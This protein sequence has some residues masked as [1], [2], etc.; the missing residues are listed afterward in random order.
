[1]VRSVPPIIGLLLAAVCCAPPA[2]AQAPAERQSSRSGA[3][4]DLDLIREAAS[5]ESAGDLR[6][7]ER[8]VAEV[9]AANP[10]SLTALLAYERLLT[11]Q[12]RPADVLPVVDRLL[13][14]DPTSGIGH[15]MRLR[16][17]ARGGDGS[18]IEAA[19]AAWIQAMPHLETPYR[20]AA[21]VWRQRAEPHRAVAVL[22]QGRH[23]IDRADALA[24]EL[25]DALLDAGDPPRAAVEWARAVGGDGRGFML[26]QRRVFE[27]PDGGAGIIPALIEQLSAPPRTPGRQ[28]S[29]VLLAIDA[30]LEPYA[31]DLATDLVTV[32]P[33]AERQP[34]FVEL[35]RR[36]DGAAMYGLA[37]WAYRV[38]LTAEPEPAAALA[39]RTRVAELALLAGDTALAA[40][41]YRQL[42]DA[43]AVGSPQ[44]R[45]ATAL[46][47]QL[48]AREGDLDAAA[49]ELDT[50]RTE[51]PQAPELDET[52]AVVAAGYLARGDAE[53]ALRLLTRV[54][55]ARSALVRARVHIQR[56]EIRPARDELLAAAPHQQGR[57][58]TETLALAALLTRLSPAGATIVA[59]AVIGPDA[60]REDSVGELL[61]GSR[62]LPDPERAAVLDFMAGIAERSGLHDDA[63]ELRSEIVAQLPQTHEAAGALL[64]LARRAL[65]R[66]DGDETAIVLLERLIVDY[67]RSSLAPQ[68]RQELQR[69]RGRSSAP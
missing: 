36:A 42:E 28:R 18:A 9:L 26:V 68:A 38:L 16:L 55:G 52:A 19:A 34:V 44:R 8:R 23:R 30:G 4:P 25:G 47:V 61:Q 33:A 53:T 35:A 1:M 32:V 51:Y 65:G 43:S 7:A 13:E 21:L 6:G 27:Q 3:A 59:R 15:Q 20:E 64:S 31:R 67:P 24:L 62:P 60:D 11:V 17:Q 56:G 57:Q 45:Q 39:M 37:A 41:E 40:T 63:D 50:F 69:L 10:A 22:E 12:G 2:S 5:L 49:A 14:V 66:S 46:R 58:A 54:P 48:T 29:A